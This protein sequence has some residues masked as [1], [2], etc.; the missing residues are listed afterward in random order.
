M[1]DELEADRPGTKT[2]MLAALQNVRPSQLLDRRLWSAL[3]MQ[4]ARE[5][6]ETVPRDGAVIAE[7]RLVRGALG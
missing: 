2:V 3:G 4:G 1:I 7:Q 6:E 5:E